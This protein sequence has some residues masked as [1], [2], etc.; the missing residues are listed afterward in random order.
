MYRKDLQ[1][2]EAGDKEIDGASREIA[3]RKFVEKARPGLDAEGQPVLEAPDGKH[4]V[5]L[6]LTRRDLQS[7]DAPAA[8]QRELMVSRL[9]QTLARSRAPR[10]SGAELREDWQLLE[11]IDQAG[12][13]RLAGTLDFGN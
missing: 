2:L 4:T 3:W 8:L 10:I 7:D 11:K 12:Q 5:E 6:G 9:K 1:A 13:E